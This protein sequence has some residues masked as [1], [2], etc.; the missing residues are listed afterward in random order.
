MRPLPL[1]AVLLSA[2]TAGAQ[3]PATPTPPDAVEEGEPAPDPDPG[4]SPVEPVPTPVVPPAPAPVAPT[5]PPEAPL[6]KKEQRR[7]E[8][9][10][11]ATDD[12]PEAVLA[13]MREADFTSRDT[14]IRARIAFQGYGPGPFS[15][16]TAFAGWQELGIDF[17]KG[18]ATWRDFTVTLGGDAHFGQAWI[19]AAL[20][21]PIANYDD[22]RFRW[23]MWDAGGGVRSGLH[24]TGLSSLDP[25]LFAGLGMSAFKFNAEVRGWADVPTAAKVTPALRAELG[26]G[27][28]IPLKAKGL[29]MGVELRYLITSQ[30]GRATEFDFVNDTE[31]A[32]FTFFSRHK[33]PKGFGWV[34][35][36]GYRF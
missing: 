13:R 19:L 15:L 32:T 11:R 31:L 5:P 3:E 36:V 21:Q 18:L 25:Y 12:S 27:L 20:S 1:I 33:P 6:T 24:Y 8:R 7:L 14:Q 30:F 28:N 2:S 34:I 16:F 22:F 9:K 10:A 35:H 4:E 26:G 17:E 29:T 23:W